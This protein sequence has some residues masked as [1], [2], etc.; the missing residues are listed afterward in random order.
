MLLCFEPMFKTTDGKTKNDIFQI[1][2]LGMLA[3]E[4]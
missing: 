3:L 1:G 2:N 4:L